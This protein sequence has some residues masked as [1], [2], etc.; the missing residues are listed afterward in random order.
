MKLYQ[1]GNTLIV[2]M[3]LLVLITIVGTLAIKSS[4]VS[5]NIATNSQ[6]QQIM[7]QSSDA[8]LFMIE[9]KTQ[10]NR[11]LAGNGLLGYLKGPANKERELVF[12][13]RREQPK[14]F[15]INA[16]SVIYWGSGQYSPKNNMIGTDGYCNVN[17][18]TDYTSGRKAVITQVAVRYTATPSDPFQFSA[19][20]TD[21]EVAKVEESERV[22][23]HSTSL[24]P[25][26]AND[27]S[28]TA[29]NDCLSKHLNLSM[30]PR[31]ATYNATKPAEKEAYEKG[32]IS[33]SKCLEGLNV[34]HT[35]QVV[36]Y[37]L[38]QDL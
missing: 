30:L 33:V 35:T 8:A 6:G 14:F 9:D 12:C 24:M 23:V 31:D 26:L 21:G 3:G 5:L 1:K 20:G 32:Q 37:K 17:L 38:S 16:A 36:E 29:I 22:M 27:V 25:T 7:T 34:P 15:D 4:L 19:R 11:Y 10:L 2:V 13:L 28:A 18:S